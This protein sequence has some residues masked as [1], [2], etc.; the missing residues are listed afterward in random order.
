MATTIEE[1]RKEATRGAS[2]RL[3]DYTL[4]EYIK[5]LDH[6]DINGATE[7]IINYIAKLEARIAALEA[8]LDGAT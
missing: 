5:P 3:D 2:R 1:L 7:P 6:G 8:R 4:T